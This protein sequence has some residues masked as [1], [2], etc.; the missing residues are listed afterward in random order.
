M[1]PAGFVLAAVLGLAAVTAFALAANDSQVTDATRQVED[2]AKKI[3]KG[4]VGEG[5]KETAKGVGE[6]VVE[7]ARYTGEKLRESGRAAE[8]EARSA[9]NHTRDGAIAF[10]R[11]V[12]D[13]FASLFSR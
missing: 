1:K 9:W 3:G 12:R 6:T 13:F 10:G 7:G 2:G 11:S 5:V 4:E 8:P